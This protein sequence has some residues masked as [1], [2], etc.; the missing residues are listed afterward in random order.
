MISKKAFVKLPRTDALV[1]LLERA[2]H[3][4]T[5]CPLVGLSGTGKDRFVEHVLTGGSKLMQP[6]E[7]LIVS[8]VAP[9]KRSLGQE[10]LATPMACIAFS[11]LWHELQKQAFSP[12]HITLSGRREQHLALY[13]ER[14]FLMLFNKV[15]AEIERRKPRVIA[16]LNTELADTSLF[17]WIME[18]RNPR[19]P[20]FALILSARL[21]EHATPD[22]PLGTI[23]N[24]S[25]AAKE[26]S[27][28]PIVLTP[29]TE[30]DFRLALA[31]LLY[32]NLN[33]EFAA[34]VDADQAAT[35]FWNRTNGN[36]WRIDRL[37]T[38]LDEELGSEGGR[39]AR[40][41][42]QDIIGRV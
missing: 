30:V 26:G 21:E 11:R 42:T 13:T 37:V 12:S 28:K 23:L 31:H 22:E 8:L 41:I 7:A 19:N 4:K 32:L 20:Q 2:I 34:D 5:I 6:Q 39:G 38:V 1:P 25:S 18:L 3:S 27:T 24:S 33:A 40:I 17:D 36:W 14:Q 16:L 10:R 15:Q 29:L 35:L 9:V